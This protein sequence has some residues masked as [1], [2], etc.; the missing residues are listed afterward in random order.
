MTT[1][2]GPAGGAPWSQ[3]ASE[4]VALLS[5][6]PTP[7]IPS[8]SCH[9]PLPTLT[10]PPEWVH[11]VS[12]PRTAPKQQLALGWVDDTDGH[13]ATLGLALMRQLHV[14]RSCLVHVH[15]GTPKPTAPAPAPVW[16]ALQPQLFPSPQDPGLRLQRD[17]QTLPKRRT[18]PC[19]CAAF[20]SFRLPPPPV[21]GWEQLLA[22]LR[23]R[24]APRSAPP[25]AFPPG[26][27]PP[28]AAPSLPGLVCSPRLRLGQG[29][30]GLSWATAVQSPVVV[31]S[32]LGTLR[33]R[34][35]SQLGA[36]IRHK[37]RYDQGQDSGN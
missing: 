6:T 4:D 3:G 14:R 13:R 7:P 1:E 5:D 19:T 23:P 10:L 33:P 12:S 18:L 2:P 16:L 20:L 31:S 8:C 17:P 30:R 25:A 29:S 36:S 22:Q 34:A 9:C 27:W 11:P 26:S 21:P 28:A 37:P 15:L 24:T 35:G 32:Q